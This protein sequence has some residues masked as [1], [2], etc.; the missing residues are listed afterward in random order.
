MSAVKV[1]PLFFLMLL[2]VWTIGPG[3]FLAVAQEGE[4]P[5]DSEWPEISPDVYS[6]GDKFF[7]IS[8][9]PLIPLPFIKESTSYKSKIKVGGTLSLSYNYFF[10]SHVFFG[11][12]LG[13]MFAQ[14]IAKDF[15]YIVPMGL[16]AGYQFI[17]GRFEIPLTLMIG[18]APQ[19][20]L[21]ENYGGL[22]VKPSA[23]FFWRFYPDW[24]FGLN[25]AWWFVPQ[26][27]K[28]GINV[29]GNFL[30]VTLSARY[31]F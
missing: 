9:G 16:R 15:I 24:S 5:I 19:V 28:E 23:S 1:R 10:T 7:S 11:G 20:R 30:E 26:W 21:E 2:G 6:R 4:L 12:E 31:H 18:F 25:T 29:Y 3:L 8:L 17:L 13:G 27:P 14:T 22:F